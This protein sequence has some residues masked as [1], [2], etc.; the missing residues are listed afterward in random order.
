MKRI[1]TR[2]EVYNNLAHRTTGG[3][4]K[5][6]IIIKKRNGVIVY[7]SKRKVEN[8][9]NNVRNKRKIRAKTHKNT[10]YFLTG[11]KTNHTHKKTKKR[12]LFNENCNTIREY[13]CPGINKIKNDKFFYEPDNKFEIHSLP[14]IDIDDLF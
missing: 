6:D 14:D 8:F 1:G 9:N 4:T 3:M 7:L 11:N 5:E 13:H 12:V 10:Q 2:E